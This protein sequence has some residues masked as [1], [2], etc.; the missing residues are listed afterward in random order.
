MI[1]IFLILTLFNNS[2]RNEEFTTASYTGECGRF[3]KELKD[4]K[5]TKSPEVK[6]D[7]TIWFE[8]HILHNV[9]N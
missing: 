7:T 6:S 4:A 2:V 1:T 8:E 5:K 9:R 3:C